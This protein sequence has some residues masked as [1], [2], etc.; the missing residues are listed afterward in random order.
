MVLPAVLPR[1]LMPC[2]PAA[3]EITDRARNLLIPFAALQQNNFHG[4]L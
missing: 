2:C 1:A 4:L 3:G